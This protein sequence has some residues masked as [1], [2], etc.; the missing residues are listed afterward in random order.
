MIT[1]EFFKWLVSFVMAVILVM[2]FI[3]GFTQPIIWAIMAVAGL[4]ALIRFGVF[5]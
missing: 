3:S 1:R 4:M 2:L 5:N